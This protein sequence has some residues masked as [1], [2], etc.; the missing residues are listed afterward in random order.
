[1]AEAE[2][3][4]ERKTEVFDEEKKEEEQPKPK[5]AKVEVF[6]EEK[7]EEEKKE[8]DITLVG[9]DMPSKQFVGGLQSKGVRISAPPPPEQTYVLPCACKR[10]QSSNRRLG[11]VDPVAKRR[12]LDMD[13]CGWCSANWLPLAVVAGGALVCAY[14]YFKAP[15]QEQQEAEEEEEE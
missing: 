3:Q 12:R 2:Q 4:P 9:L 1:M 14:Q 8:E 7:K 13:G 5:E 10:E 6:D 11:D 15:V